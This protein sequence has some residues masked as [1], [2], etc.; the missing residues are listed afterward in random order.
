MRV[1]TE[2]TLRA[3]FKNNT[4]KQYLVSKKTII[5][6]S[7]RQY[8]KD[9]CVEL[10]YK[11]GDENVYKK[12]SLGKDK[13]SNVYKP[14]KA[15]DKKIAPKFIDYYTGGFYEEK[16]EYMTHMYGNKLVYKDDERIIFRGKIDSFQSLLL[17]MMVYTENIKLDSLTNDLDEILKFV[18][19]I[20]RAEVLEEPLKQ[21]ELL[22]LSEKQIRDI[23]HNPKKHYN[24]DHILPDYEMGETIIKLN[25]L[26]SAIREVEIAGI[27]TFR[28]G[29]KVDRVD[30]LKSLNRLSSVI[31]IIMCKYKV[32]LY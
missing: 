26:R 20:L 27:N 31:Y 4:P 8:L 12:E 24:I 28:N 22:G 1:L 21:I 7:A 6:P 25:S 15:P 2:A 9:K 23:S 3:E 19:E 14:I 32:G 5:T 10:V 11:D 16:P 30:I 13:Q 17:E 29:H 18:R